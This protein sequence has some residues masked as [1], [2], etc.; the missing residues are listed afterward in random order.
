MLTRNG[1]PHGHYV[2]SSAAGQQ[3]LAKVRLDGK[4]GPVVILPDGR[5]LANPSNSEILDALGATSVADTACDVVVVGGGPAGL[6]TAVYSASEGL[7]TIVVE[8]EAVG[9]QAG[10]STLIRNYLGFPRGIGGAQLAQRAYDQAWL[11]G[12]KFVF[13][14]RAVALRSEGRE[15]FVE[16]EDGMTIRARA[17]VIATGASYR[18]L[19]VPSIERFCGA[20]FFYV[21]PV[22]ASFM[23]GRDAIVVGGGNSAGQAVAHLSKYARRVVHVVR[24]DTLA[25]SMSDYLVQYNAHRPNVELRLH[26]ELTH[27]EGEGALRAVTMRDRSTGATRRFEGTVV[28]ALIGAEP[29]TGWL[30]DALQGTRDGYVATGADRFSGEY[31]CVARRP[32]R[33]ET[34]MPGVFAVGD[35]RAGS[36]KRVAAAAGEGSMVVATIHDYLAQPAAI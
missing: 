20:G 1:I 11:F 30:T 33:F 29:H 18:R 16:L 17:V 15:R 23:K 24:G 10:T 8:A 13:A 25:R 26:T 2:A 36:V 21:V 32:G 4:Q 22:E 5:A 6:A 27:G 28:F 12:A 34:S 3:L 31:E 14:R 7:R 9:G 19:G 35:V